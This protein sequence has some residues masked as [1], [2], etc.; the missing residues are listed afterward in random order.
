[1]INFKWGPFFHA[2][3]R[4]AQVAQVARAEAG[5]GRNHPVQDDMP[6]EIAGAVRYAAQHGE[7]MN[8][9]GPKP[10]FARLEVMFRRQYTW[11]EIS[12]LL[13]R[14]LEAIQDDMKKQHFFHYP[15]ESAKAL[16]EA[17]E[18]WK[19]VFAAYPKARVEVLPGLDCAAFGDNVG[20]IFH[21]M[22]VA[23]IGLRAVA[24]ERGVKNVRTKTPIEYG[25]WGQ[26]IDA[27]ERAVMDIR[28]KSAGPKKDAALGF[29]NTII[30]D[31][32]ALLD[33]YRDKT[34]HFRAE[35]D[36]GQAQ[37]AIFRVHS[38][39]SM[40]ATRLDENTKGKIKWGL[41]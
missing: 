9:D 16:N 8:L 37:S 10:T 18:Y 15:Q 24:V 31:L 12:E 36:H 39:M 29:Y 33:V 21:M 4:L 40:I 38:L 17:E 7:Y 26:V 14:A 19:P 20:C 35:Y 11:G 5:H 1:M 41:R 6:S 30:S 2:L 23:E 13:D 25:T 27:T 3:E 32:R 28:Q 22:R 34:M